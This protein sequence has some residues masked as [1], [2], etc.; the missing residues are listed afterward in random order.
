[1]TVQ[2]IRAEYTNLHGMF[3]AWDA[4]GNRYT[5]RRWTGWGPNLVYPGTVTSHGS[6]GEIPQ[7][8]LNR[9]LGL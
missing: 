1:M 3:A 7:A 5:V 2:I 4:D 8:D 9:A 6:I